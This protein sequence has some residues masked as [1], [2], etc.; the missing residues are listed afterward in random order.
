[1]RVGCDVC[2]LAE[3]LLYSSV[4]GIGLE[5]AGTGHQD[6]VVLAVRKIVCLGA[7]DCCPF[8]VAEIEMQMSSVDQYRS[9]SAMMLMQRV[10]SS[11]VLQISERLMADCHVP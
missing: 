11:C 3:L 2:I 1:M 9:G 6:Q 7:L 4:L 8:D 5:D 10:N